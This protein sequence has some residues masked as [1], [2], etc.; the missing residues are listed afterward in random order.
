MTVRQAAAALGIE[1]RRA[2]WLLK[3]AYRFRTAF[4]SGTCWVSD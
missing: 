1:V 2:L 4:V 3:N